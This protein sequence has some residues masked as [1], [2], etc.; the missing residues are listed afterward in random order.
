LLEA[1]PFTSIIGTKSF[2]FIEI[3]MISPTLSK[4][5]APRPGSVNKND[6]NIHAC[7]E[8]AWKINSTE[9]EMSSGEAEII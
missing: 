1:L 8:V 2:F 7:N 4:R 9:T 5:R 3:S 6:S